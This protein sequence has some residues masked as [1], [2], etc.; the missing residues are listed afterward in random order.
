MKYRNFAF[1]SPIKEKISA[2]LLVK[3]NSSRDNPGM[4]KPR[5]RTSQVY[6][7]LQLEEKYGAWWSN[8]IFG[9][10]KIL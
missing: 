1:S 10:N 2:I 8:L 9:A 7:R 5:T 6:T 4:M 3:Q